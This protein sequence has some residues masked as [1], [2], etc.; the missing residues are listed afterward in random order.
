MSDSEP[1]TQ[2]HP[3]SGPRPAPP[4]KPNRPAA[5]TH[6]HAHTPTSHA[7]PTPAV[8]PRPASRP[9]PSAGIGITQSHGTAAKEVET[10][11]G[12]E[13]GN[14]NPPSGDGSPV[15]NRRPTATMPKDAREARGR[16]QAKAEAHN[17]AVAEGSDEMTVR[18]EDKEKGT[19]SHDTDIH[20]EPSDIHTQEGDTQS[21]SGITDNGK[22]HSESQNGEDSD[23]HLDKE[24]SEGTATTASEVLEDVPDRI[25]EQTKLEGEENKAHTE[26]VEESGSK[27]KDSADSSSKSSVKIGDGAADVY[28][29]T[30]SQPTAPS[31]T[32][33][34]LDARPQSIAVFGNSP[35]LHPE[36]NEKDE[37]IQS[38][39]SIKA[40]FESSTAEHGDKPYPHVPPKPGKRFMMPG[41]APQFNPF[42]GGGMPSRPIKP[43]PRASEDENQT[44][45]IIAHSG[46]QFNPFAAVLYLITHRDVGDAKSPIAGSPVNSRK[47]GS[48]IAA[49]QAKMSASMREAEEK[50]LAKEE[51]ERKE[52]EAAEAAG[53]LAPTSKITTARKPGRA[54]GARPGRR[55]PTRANPVFLTD[56]SVQRINY[57][58]T[59]TAKE[60]VAM[61][62]D[63]VDATGVTDADDY[64]ILEVTQA[65]EGESDT[66]RAMNDDE[67]LAKVKDTWSTP[68]SSRF[69]WAKKGDTFAVTWPE[70]TK[71][72]GEGEEP[73][74]ETS[75]EDADN[76][77]DTSEDKVDVTTQHVESTVD[78]TECPET[79]E[80]QEQDADELKRESIDDDSDNTHDQK[81]EENSEQESGSDEIKETPASP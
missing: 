73:K 42:A 45:P 37:S 34:S 33:K 10:S 38:L 64:E 76:P 69:V 3:A 50:Q 29:V 43:R 62:A 15:A 41:G 49:L 65:E 5:G 68:D 8:R 2:P 71:K 24:D 77:I 48:K 55:A 32:S 79:T 40:A 35:A 16:V 59:S 13:G 11:D 56:G 22:K 54:G 60:V 70:S 61:V 20:T 51:E 19:E 36:D 57:T 6:V 46:P 67:V 4:T 74:M 12:G 18:G 66:H 21:V 78:P 53:N 52:K 30:E 25:G 26:A 47:V 72:S 28:T 58:A 44:A 9:T 31:R 75:A 80:V 14:S 81:K 17:N 23:N 63:R 7:R 39:D 27:V 1:D